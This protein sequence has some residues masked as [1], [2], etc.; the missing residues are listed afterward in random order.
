LHASGVTPRR[1]EHLVV[2]ANWVRSTQVVRECCRRHA[3]ALTILPAHG[4]GGGPTTRAIL[5]WDKK[6]GERLGL[7]W[8][9]GTVGGQ[10]G[11][12]FD[13]DHWKTYA[14][15]RLATAIGDPGSL[16]FHQGEH[17]MLPDHLTAEQTITVEARGRSADQ[18]K[19][20]P[21]RDNH[22]LD[23]LVMA[24]VAASVSGINATAHGRPVSFGAAKQS[25]SPGFYCSF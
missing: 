22:L 6:A 3:N 11:L 1:I 7:A 24:S 18:W 5:D 25:R 14:A 19:L 8:R 16:T 4:R 20:L 13:A 10:R 15:G 2:D 23:C 21:G 9:V 12:L 17:E